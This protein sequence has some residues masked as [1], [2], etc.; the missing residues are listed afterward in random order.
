[1]AEPWSPRYN[2][3]PSQKVPVVLGQT[4]REI[5]LL[6]WGLIPSWAKDAKIGNR[7]INARAETLSVKPS[8]R[9]AFKQRR[10]LVPADGFFEWKRTG[11]GKVPHFVC[12][13]SRR[14]MVFAGLWENWQ[15]SGQN[16]DSFT[17]VTIAPNQLLA[18]IHDRMP[19]IVPGQDFSAWLDPDTEPSV[20]QEILRPFTTEALEVFPVSSQ[21]NSPAHD[22]AEL[23]LPVD[24]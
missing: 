13:Q 3:A 23:V 2:I 20:A 7:L 12:L 21:V 6:Q 9:N 8:F 14:I 10:C 15:T 4:G 24:G 1:M 17:I 5:R 16:I 18:S 11:S 19:A 22:F